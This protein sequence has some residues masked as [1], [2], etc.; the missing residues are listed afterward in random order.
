MLGEGGTTLSKLKSAVREFQASDER[1][2]NKEL[3]IVIDSLEGTFCAN[4]RQSELSGE[5]LVAGNI[6]AASWIARTCGMSVTSAADRVCV[7]SQ[8]EALPK[9]VAA[10]RSGE[11]SFQSASE[12]CHLRDKHG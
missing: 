2:D 7:G 9:V 6:T 8:L 12:L 5:H 10:L 4:A 11:I 1:V 3:R